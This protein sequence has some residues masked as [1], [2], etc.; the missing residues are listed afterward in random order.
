MWP[1]HRQ[2]YQQNHQGI[3][4]GSSYSDMTNSL[5]ELP[6]ESPIELLWIL[7]DSLEKS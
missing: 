5:L 6:M 1:I 3:Q 2:N 4:T 7:G